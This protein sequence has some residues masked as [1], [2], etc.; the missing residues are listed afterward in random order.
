MNP[1]KPPKEDVVEVVKML[2]LLLKFAPK[3]KRGRPSKEMVRIKKQMRGIVDE[4]MRKI[5]IDQK[6]KQK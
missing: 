4:E 2:S 5:K 1:Q 3:T 6:S